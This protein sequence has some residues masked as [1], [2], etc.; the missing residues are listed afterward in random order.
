MCNAGD[1]GESGAKLED[2]EG[3]LEC[4]TLSCLSS[5]KKS[6]IEV[7]VETVPNGSDDEEELFLV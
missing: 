3:G 7:G 1:N 4:S 5:G 2:D 6:D